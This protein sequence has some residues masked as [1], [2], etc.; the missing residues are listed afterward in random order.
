MRGEMKQKSPEDWQPLKTTGRRESMTL[1]VRLII[2]S[3]LSWL[4]RL[5][6]GLVL[7]PA[8]WDRFDDL[9]EGPNRLI[10]AK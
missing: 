6:E 2:C 5:G 8:G 3:D 9:F 7:L 1:C 10:I 4:C